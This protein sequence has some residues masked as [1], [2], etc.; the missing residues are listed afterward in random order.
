MI[1]TIN[2]G[3]EEKPVF[4]DPRG[5][6]KGV[7]HTYTEAGSHV[8]T[9]EGYAAGTVIEAGQPVP[10]GIAVAEEWMAPVAGTAEAAATVT[11]TV[12]ASGTAAA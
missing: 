8:A 10:P 12:A 11:E 7:P 3:T 5:H 6:P 2:V 4:V 9:Q 1:E